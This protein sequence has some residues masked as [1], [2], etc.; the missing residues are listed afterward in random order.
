MLLSK[1]E[2]YGIR[3]N[4][5]CLI[6]SYLTGRSQ[7]TEVLGEKS[8]LDDVLFGV[9]QGSVLGPLLFI[10]YINDIINCVNGILGIK[11]VLYADDT[12]VFIIGNNRRDLIRTGAIVLDAINRY[13]KSNLLHIN[14]GKCCYIHFCKGKSR[15][16]NVDKD[17]QHDELRISGKIIEEVDSTKFLGVTIDKHLTWQAHCESLHNKLK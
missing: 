7:Y 5:N 12:N 6:R 10:I 9:P 8:R 16:D 2:H 17:S 3:G 15:L 4:A 1:L 13:M 14:V 11:L